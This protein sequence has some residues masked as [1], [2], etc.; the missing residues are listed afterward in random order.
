LDK[1]ENKK[2]GNIVLP[3][4]PATPSSE[5]LKDPQKAANYQQDMANYNFAIQTLQ[6]IQ[7]EEETTQSNMA[8]SRHDA[9][10]AIINNMKS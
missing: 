8:K 1:K 10:M 5:D 7:N 4:R 3:Q 9:M 6:H 2:M